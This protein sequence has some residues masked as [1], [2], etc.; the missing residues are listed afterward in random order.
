MR[1]AMDV[2]HKREGDGHVVAFPCV[3]PCKRGGDFLFRPVWNRDA[4]TEG[5]KLLV[6][7]RLR[8]GVLRNEG[9]GGGHRRSGGTCLD[10]FT[11]IHGISFER[12]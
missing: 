2:R 5:E 10:E 12:D 6:V 8:L 1:S 9:K 3:V 4:A 7:R 11:S